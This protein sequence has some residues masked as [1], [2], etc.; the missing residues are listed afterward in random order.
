VL[1]RDTTARTRSACFS[2]LGRTIGNQSLFDGGDIGAMALKFCEHSSPFGAWAMM[3]RETGFEPATNSLEGCDS[4]PELLPLTHC[5]RPPRKEVG[6]TKAYSTSHAAR[7]VVVRQ[8][9]RRK[10]LPR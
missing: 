2:A 8:A 9:F 1:Q 6:Q 7:S 3:E 10:V 4:T 5:D